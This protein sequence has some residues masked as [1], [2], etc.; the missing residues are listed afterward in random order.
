MLQ[1]FLVAGF[2]FSFFTTRKQRAYK[3]KRNSNQRVVDQAK[4]FMPCLKIY[5]TTTAEFDC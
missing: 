4:F 5:Q 2:L 3:S 1:I